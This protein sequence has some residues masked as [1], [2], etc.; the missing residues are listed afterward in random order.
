MR[1]L[2]VVQEAFIAISGNKIRSGLTVLGIVIGIA[3]VIALTAIGQ[4]SQAS[5]TA[6]IEAAGSNLLTVSPGVSFGSG[7]V[8][9]AFGSARTLKTGD[10]DAIAQLD[11]AKA[12]APQVT[13]RYQ[14][15]AS[16]GNSNAQVIAT[17][18]SYQSVRN[19]T[20]ANGSFFSDQQNQDGSRV[21]VLGS[22]IATDLFGD[23]ASGG[24]DP[25]GQTIRIKTS[26]FT[27]IGVTTAK[28]GFG[29]DNADNAIYVP[30]TTGQRLLAGQTTYLSQVSVTAVDQKSMDQ[31]QTDITDL[32]LQRHGISSTDSADFRVI[33]QADLASTMTSTSRTLTLL[34]AAIAGISLVVGGIGIM[35]MMLT[36]VTER[37][38]EIGLRKAIGAKRGDI[39][40]QFLVEAV[41]LTFVSG[42]IGIVLGW[43]VSLAINHFAGLETVITVQWV[44]IA[45]GLSALIGIVFGIYPARRAAGLNPIEAL[46][47]E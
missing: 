20:L 11:L 15:V 8:R 19:V 33:N 12:V 31:L 43:L 39:S 21:A 42:I 29:P 18:P 45:F 37:T 24:T 27:V 25:I 44:V 2:D 34:L 38:R 26:K 16:S 9:G 36:T 1:I 22:Q 7:G 23:P 4:G 47:Y 5:I 30:L 13:G 17:T 41:M 35:N 14:I 32:L 3:S 46:R 40:L 6:N 10:A 28:G